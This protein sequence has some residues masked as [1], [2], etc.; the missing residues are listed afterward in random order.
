[1]QRLIKVSKVIISSLLIWIIAPLVSGPIWLIILLI[2][3]DFSLISIGGILYTFIMGLFITI[4]AGFIM[5]LLVIIDDSK[6][7][8]KSLP[9]Q[10]WNIV[11]SGI[12]GQLYLMFV[13][14]E[15]TEDL[16]LR[17]TASVITI[18]TAMTLNHFYRISIVKRINLVE[19][20]SA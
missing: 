10:T 5:G 8:W 2:I 9:W 7:L 13:P 12:I 16:S 19:G 4:P 6:V 3:G 14:L 17:I 1:M 20:Q 18:F 11:I 15:N